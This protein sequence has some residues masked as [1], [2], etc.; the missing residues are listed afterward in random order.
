M[1][2]NDAGIDYAKGYKRSYRYSEYIVSC[3]LY[4]YID[5]SRRCLFILQG[6]EGWG[7]DFNS[8]TYVI[9]EHM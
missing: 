2:A 8:K 3:A 5:V 7:N 4:I 6:G 9:I 1:R